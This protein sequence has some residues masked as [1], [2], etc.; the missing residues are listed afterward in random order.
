M[1]VFS[2]LPIILIFA[3]LALLLS[4]TPYVTRE[5]ISFGVTISE[6]NYYTPILRKLR[7]TFATVSLIGN[8]MVIL[9]CLYLLRS[10]N[11]ESTAMITGV[12][13][14]IFIVFW[15]ALNILF[16][17]KMKKIK[18]TLTTVEAPQRV[19]IDTT[20]R[21][22][23]LTYSNYWFL[24]HIAIIVAIAIISILN[25]KSLPNV[26]PIKYD[27][28]GNVTSSVPKTYLS[29]LAINLVQ[30][31]IIALMML[32][33][34]SIK[35][36]KQQLTTSDPAQFAAKNIQFRRK[37]SLFTMIAG[38]LLTILFAFIQM[39]MFVL[40]LVLLTGISF[41][42]P[43]VIVIGAV[44]LS[45]TGRQGGGKIR[46]HQED[47]ERSMEQ[48]VNDDDNWKL[49][50]IYFN[51]NDPSFTVE[52]RYGIGWTINFARP[53]S[54]VL[55]LFIIAIVVISRVLSQ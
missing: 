3:P 2:I 48:P 39:N 41:I 49:G 33:N 45:L 14:M 7:I 28:Q 8:G 36:S 55:L 34:W 38:L 47:R 5:R 22:N 26:I 44:W 30:L 15:A 51:A 31:G 6:Y 16:H 29:V 42:I 52:K 11:E 27:L 40:N 43:V 4:F 21:Q 46:N 37:W 12:F 10:A 18:G 20:F 54:W 9:V 25:Y 24:I 17:F 1:Q 13:T 53:L 32:V 35:T 19:K 23:K 50:F